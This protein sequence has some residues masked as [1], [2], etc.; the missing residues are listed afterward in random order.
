LLPRLFELSHGKISDTIGLVSAFRGQ[1]RVK[2]ATG[3]EIR[4]GR[5]TNHCSG[6]GYR[7]FFKV[8]FFVRDRFGGCWVHRFSRHAAEL[9]R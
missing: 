9:I 1:F 5:I 6:R 2:G 7:V 4:N 8:R 3:F